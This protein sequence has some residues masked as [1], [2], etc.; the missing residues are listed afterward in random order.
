MVLRVITA[1]VELLDAASVHVLRAIVGSTIRQRSQA[2]RQEVDDGQLDVWEE[3]LDLRGPLH[4][5]EAGTDDENCG[6]L[7]VP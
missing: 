1:A 6:L 4:A 5:D 7:L 3:M 2:A